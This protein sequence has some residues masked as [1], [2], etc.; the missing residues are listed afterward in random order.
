MAGLSTT[1]TTTI[2]ASGL[3]DKHLGGFGVVF[4]NG[5]VSRRGFRASFVAWGFRMRLSSQTGRVKVTAVVDDG[6]A[7]E[8][9]AEGGLKAAVVWLVRALRGEEG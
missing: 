3:L 8:R 1:T 4:A 9:E 6:L 5:F 2:T 7:G